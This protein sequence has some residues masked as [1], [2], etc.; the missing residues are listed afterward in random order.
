MDLQV[1]EAP[2]ERHMA[3][4]IEPVLIAEEDHLPLQ[5]GLPDLLD[6]VVGEVVGQVD[7]ADLG[8]DRHRHRV[9][10]DGHAAEATARPARPGGR[11]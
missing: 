2:A 5:Q 11:P 4:T 10:G 1:T 6:R 8:A 3:R 7:T 9:D